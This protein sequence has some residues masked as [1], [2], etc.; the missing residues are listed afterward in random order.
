AFYPG[1]TF[2]NAGAGI[3]TKIYR[4]AATNP[5]NQSRI[6]TNVSLLSGDDA[7]ATAITATDLPTAFS[8]TILGPE[9]MRLSWE[10]GTHDSVLV[11]FRLADGATNTAIS[12][13]GADTTIAN[14][15][16]YL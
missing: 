9:S 1:Q 8:D 12:N 16:A 6:S 14:A 7:L 4:A 2:H 10:N 5:W 11:L 3:K 15:L 13:L